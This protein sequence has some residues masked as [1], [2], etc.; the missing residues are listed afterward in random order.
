MRSTW[1]WVDLARLPGGRRAVRVLFRIGWSFALPRSSRSAMPAAV[2][3][4][5]PAPRAGPAWAWALA[6]PV[7][8]GLAVLAVRAGLGGF[9]QL[10][11]STEAWLVAHVQRVLLAGDYAAA[12]SVSMIPNTTWNSLYP[13]LVVGLCRLLGAAPVVVGQALS[14]AALGLALVA[15]ARCWGAAG[16]LVVGLAGALGLLFPPVVISAGMARYDLLALALVLTVA[17]AV[18]TAL[19]RRSLLAWGAAGLLAGLSFHSREFMLAPALGALG[20]GW[21]L[22]ALAAWRAPGGAGRLRHPGLALACSW[23]GLALGVLP[24]PLALGLD[25]LSGLHALSSY[26]LHNRFGAQRSVPELLYLDRFGVAFA[27][28]A[29]GF[30]AALIRPGRPGGR[31]AALVILGVLL[32][33]GAFLFSRQQSPQYYL[34]AH[35]LLLSGAAGLVGLLPWR[36]AR[37]LVLVVLVAPV[38]P[39]AGGLIVDGLDPARSTAGRLH[40]E[41]WPAEP[42]EPSRVMA[43]GLE[44]AAGQPLIVVSGAVENIDALARIEHG[45]PVAFLFREWL[46]RI[47]EAVVLCDAQD[48][49]VLS[50]EGRDQPTHTI[51]GGMRMDRLETANLVAELWVVPGQQ[52]PPTREPRCARGAQIRGACLQQAWLQGGDEALIHR[53][54]T[55]HERFGGL[56]GWRSMWW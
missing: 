29:L 12:T 7:G 21:A 20:V 47:D 51:R 23:V 56:Q 50:V 22:A 3:S 45:R 25:P 35:A 19:E 27:V 24:L 1:L 36:W 31:R 49:L 9:G 38:A 46:E 28:G 40:T 37:P 2:A 53:I 26:S 54:L 16:G 18:I 6:V 43:W 34:L 10:Q 8:M 39:W 4:T 55:Q 5:P 11:G 33:F 17:W 13:A 14:A 41:A 52:A 32:P 42:G 48:V 15:L 44:R 30:L